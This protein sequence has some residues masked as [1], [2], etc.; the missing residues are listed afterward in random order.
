MM[1]T[2]V[3]YLRTSCWRIRNRTSEVQKHISCLRF[4]F[5]FNSLNFRFLGSESFRQDI[6]QFHFS[7]ADETFINVDFDIAVD[8]V[9]GE[10]KPFTRFQ[11]GKYFANIRKYIYYEKTERFP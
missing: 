3:W 7:R 4:F 1:S 2:N 9:Q 10:S 6:G 11:L 8:M 5:Y